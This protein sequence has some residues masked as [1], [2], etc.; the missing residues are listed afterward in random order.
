MNLKTFGLPA[1]KRKSLVVLGAGASRGASF[2]QD[3]T[4]ALPPL[5]RDFFQQLTRMPATPAADRLLEFVRAEYGHELGV[6]MEQFFSE[7][8]YTDRFHSELSVDRGP[9]I[10]RYERALDDFMHCLPDLLETTTSRPCGYHSVLVRT[11]QSQDCIMSFN[12]DCIMDRA[13]RDD[14]GLRWDPGKRSYGFDIAQ[15]A[16]DWRTTTR[17]RPRELHIALL[18]MHGSAN[19][20]RTADDR[21]RLAR[22]TSEV[23]DL[24]GSIIPPTWFKDLQKFP[25]ADIWRQAR[26]NVRTARAMIVVGYSVPETD[27]FT[28]SLFKVEA[29]SKEKRERLDLLVLVNRDPAARRRFLDLIAGGV[30]PRTRILEYDTFADVYQVIMRNLS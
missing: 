25:F 11:L 30:E 21:V 23:S 7:A 3:P 26:R 6:S 5:D 20:V 13:L 27:L 19:W 9:K 16:D 29:G 1:L 2:V 12:Y 8:D 15:G 24:T 14:A 18:K 28:R 17:G 4:S 22:S 10:K